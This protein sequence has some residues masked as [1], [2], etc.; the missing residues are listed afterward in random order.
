MTRRKV[1]RITVEGVSGRSGK[2]WIKT[3]VI[4]KPARRMHG[5]NLDRCWRYE[6]IDPNNLS[7]SPSDLINSYEQDAWK[8]WSNLQRIGCTKRSFK[9]AE[10]AMLATL[11][12]ATNQDIAFP[13][14]KYIEGPMT[15]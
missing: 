1:V 12:K 7:P 11:R 2:R 9:E 14:D 10:S 8:E 6:P 3:T 4:I 13:F 5:K 15:P